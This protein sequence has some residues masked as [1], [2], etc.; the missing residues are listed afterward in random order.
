LRKH[1]VL[2]GLL[3]ALL[4]VSLVARGL[5]LEQLGSNR[6]PLW[7]RLD[8][9]SALLT[10]AKIV[11]Y[12][13]SKLLFPSELSYLPPFVPALSA[14]DLLGLFWLG[15]LQ[16]ATVWLLYPSERHGASRYWLFWFLATLTPVSGIVSLE[17]FVK[18]HHA[19]LPAVGFC[20]LLGLL[21]DHG[22]ALLEE[23][24]AA[25]GRSL[26][27]ALFA[28]CALTLSLATASHAQTFAGPEA[29][30][31]RIIELEPQIPE[32]AFA[33]P[34]MNKSAHR[35]AVVRMNL[36]LLQ[37]KAGR[38]DLALP[39][40]AR[41]AQLA[42]ADELAFQ[43]RFLQGDC[44]KRL[45]QLAEAKADFEQA[46]GMNSRRPEPALQLALIA[47][48]QRDVAEQA[49]Y[50][51]IACERGAEQACREAARIH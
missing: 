47:Y 43:V 35:F 4:V 10:M 2:L 29:A 11:G 30:Y 28:A 25:A 26:G 50:L 32:A 41:A 34:A 14:G 46:L 33:H 44:R 7:Y 8:A 22:I 18:E 24:R 9:F 23:R 5:V 36:A 15:A 6:K 49:R 19:Y 27:L 13:P 37:L 3:V 20:M 39:N 1:A 21:S 48:M 51:G 17:Y 16:A 40:L 42:R 45:G 38:C 31:Q 12:Y